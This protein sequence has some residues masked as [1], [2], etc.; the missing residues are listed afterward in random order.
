MKLNLAVLPIFL[1]FA[2]NCL[3]QA[4]PPPVR[5]NDPTASIA[6]DVSK[7][8]ASVQTLTKTLQDSVDRSAKAQGIV[9]SDK[10]QRYITGMQ[11]LVQAEQRVAALQKQQLELVEKEGQMR[12]RSAQ[13]ESDLNTQSIDRSVAFEGSTQTPE[14]KEI[15]L[16]S[17]QA[18]R[19]AFQTYL[20]QLQRSLLEKGREVDEAQAFVER[21]RRTLLPQ[22]ERELAQQ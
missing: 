18:D 7:I 9:L 19:I 21:L 5:Q 17:L 8:A 4:Q 22:I 3:S 1:L 6:Y 14:L 16:R 13:V 11:I 2:C 20:A 15:R 10:Y 12:K